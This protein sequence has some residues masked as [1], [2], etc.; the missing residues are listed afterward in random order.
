MGLSPD[1]L[2]TWLNNSTIQQIN[3]STS[4]PETINKSTGRRIS[5]CI[6]MHTF[7]HPCRIDEIIDICNRYHIAVVEDAA[8]SLGSFYK[9]KHTGTFA[10][11]GVLSFNGNKI[12]TTGGG[13][14]ILF[15]D[16]VLAKHAKHLTTQAKIS[17]PWE[18]F[19]DEIG[20]NL[21][22]PNIN[23]AIGLAQMENLPYFLKLKREIADHY[24][25]YFSKTNIVFIKE[26]LNSLSNYWLNSILLKNK[27]ERDY[28]LNFTNTN[29]IRTRPAWSLMNTLPM[30]SHCQKDNLKTASSVAERLVN[31]PSSAIVTD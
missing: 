3:K 26:P 10:K 8:E 15:Q 30:Y 29:G 2:K 4:Q 28:F 5:A 1:L 9:G 31:I 7:G 19:H 11:I 24:E 23:A 22:M 20:Y 13:G 17:H 18:I 12:I 16:E 6:P 25:D 27:S 14:M 21:R